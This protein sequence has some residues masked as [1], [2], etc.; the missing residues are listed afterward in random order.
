L[1]IAP[2]AAHCVRW[3]KPGSAF[4]LASTQ[5]EL[6][7]LLTTTLAEERPRIEDAGLDVV[8]AFDVAEVRVQ[9]GVGE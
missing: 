4:P 7:V 3:A 9:A 5:G 1:E 6:K 8:Y 2:A